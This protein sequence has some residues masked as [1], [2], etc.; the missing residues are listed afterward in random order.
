MLRSFSRSGNPTLNVH[1]G[2]VTVKQVDWGGL[3]EASELDR[4]RE[5]LEPLAV[6]VP[7]V[8]TATDRFLVLETLRGV[9]LSDRGLWR[10]TENARAAGR[11]LAAVHGPPRDDGAVR[12]HGDFSPVNLLWSPTGDW[13]LLDP[14]PNGYLSS[15][16]GQ[17]GPRRDE[18]LNYLFAT[19]WR[20]LR[21]PSFG[22]QNQRRREWATAG[23]DFLGGYREAMLGPQW[24]TTIGAADLMSYGDAYI[25]W[26]LG[27]QLGAS[28]AAGG[29]LFRRRWRR[30]VHT[31]GWGER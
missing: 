19:G 11:I 21:S 12:W 3:R 25:R 4:L 30:F 22:V 10:A 15:T 5:A 24:A 29:S 31:S 20:V 17:W 9:P 2:R 8:L 27:R 18:L 1:V 6:Q 13:G 14:A 28:S 23:A 7:R 26:R 16:Y